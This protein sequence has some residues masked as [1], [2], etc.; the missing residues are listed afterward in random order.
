[1]LTPDQKRQLEDM[2][3]KDDL[4]SVLEALSE[5]CDLKAEHLVSNWQDPNTA[6]LWNRAGKRLDACANTDAVVQ[7]SS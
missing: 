6:R 2:V 7:V 5:I 4:K 1:M 3:D